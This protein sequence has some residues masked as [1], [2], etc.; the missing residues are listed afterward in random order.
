MSYRFSLR[1]RTNPRAGRV[2]IWPNSFA[3]ARVADWLSGRKPSFARDN[4]VTHFS[5][6]GQG[7]PRKSELHPAES[8][9][10]SPGT[11]GAKFGRMAL[12]AELF[13]SKYSPTIGF[14]LAHMVKNK[15]SLIKTFETGTYVIDPS[16]H[17]NDV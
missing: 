7:G 5:G 14:V 11:N 4:R 15:G 16:D 12:V 17:E 9:F 8:I 2:W 1:V 6:Q 13:L 10:Q 3:P